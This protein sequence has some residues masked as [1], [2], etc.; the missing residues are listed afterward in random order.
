MLKWF[1]L[2]VP[3]GM[4]FLPV[5]VASKPGS[6]FLHLLGRVDDWLEQWGKRKEQLTAILLLTPALAVLGVFGILPLVLAIGLSLFQGIGLD[7]HFTALRNYQ[8]ALQDPDFWNALRVTLYFALGSIPVSL[9]ISFILAS[10][11]KQ[12]VWGRSFFRTVYF[13]PYVTSVVAAAIVWRAFLFPQGGPLN[14]LLLMAGVPSEHLPRWLLEPRGVLSL[15]SGGLIP[16][17]IGPSLA[18]CCVILFEIWHSVGFMTVILLAALTAIPRELEEAAKMDGANWFQRARHVTIPL[19]SPTL[20]FLLVVSGIKSFQAFN[21]FY[22]LTGNGRGPLNSTQSLTVYIFTN[23]Y[24]YQDLGYGAA[25]A[26]LL[27]CAIV[28]LTLVQWH[29]VGR[30]VHYE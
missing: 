18:L 11:L 6:P 4:L 28:A 3:L 2:L 20:L 24:E 7:M 12:I 22:A 29:V 25:V 16:G 19:I 13:L 14:A 8:R 17:N 27:A 30:R 10:L 5:L 15:L 26:V 23:L 1:L 21:S 9:L